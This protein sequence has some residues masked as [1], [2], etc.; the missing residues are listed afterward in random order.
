MNPEVNKKA[1]P[2]AAAQ[3]ADRNRKVGLQVAV[4][5]VLVAL[6]AGIGISVAMKKS[7]AEDVGPVPSLAGQQAATITDTGAIRIGKPD[8]K[9]TVRV[10]SDM[11]CPACR[12]FETANS[13]V[14]QDEVDKGTAAVEYNIVAFL[15]VMSSGTRYSSRA[16][17]AAYAVAESDASKFQAWLAA[18]YTAQPK[19]GGFGLTDEQIIQIAKD[20][21]YTDPA[22]AQAITA[23]KYDRYVQKITKDVSESGVN[24][25]PSVWVDGQQVRTQQAMFA[26]DGLRAV[27]DAA[28][29]GR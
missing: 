7:S 9:V 23:N 26:P 11:Q 1:N 29:A 27:I 5:A 8:A 18:M 13:R 12:M 25:T 21:G 15:D 3:R 4:A 19:E 28:A 6:I 24:A 22:V 20:A 10:V 16:A 2:V 14:L 17:N